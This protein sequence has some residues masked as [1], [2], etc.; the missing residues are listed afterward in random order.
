MPILRR[1]LSWCSPWHDRAG[2]GFSGTGPLASNDKRFADELPSALRD[3]GVRGPYILV[4][5]AS[6]GDIVRVFADLYMSDVA[7]MVLIDPA[8][9]D[10]ETSHDLEV[11]DPMGSDRDI[12]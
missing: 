5:H 12:A 3:G 2:A 9:R 10:V 7:G 8:E 11:P 4:G 6:G 1:F